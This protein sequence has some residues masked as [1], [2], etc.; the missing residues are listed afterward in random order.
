[1]FYVD[2]DDAL[3]Q[4]RKADSRR[5]AIWVMRIAS[6][7]LRSD[8]GMIALSPAGTTCARSLALSARGALRYG[9]IYVP[10]PIVRRA[11]S[12]R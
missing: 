11:A 2:L 10:R 5:P 1:L 12:T 7:R 9:R 8:G 3:E 4:P 6:L